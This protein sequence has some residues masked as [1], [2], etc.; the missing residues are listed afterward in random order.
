[1]APGGS[2]GGEHRSQAIMEIV[3]RNLPCCH[4]PPTNPYPTHT[5]T[6]GDNRL[7]PQPAAL[8]AVI[9]QP[10]HPQ[11]ADIRDGAAARRQRRQRGCGEAAAAGAE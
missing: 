1:V 9:P 7:P 2:A 4:Q 10:H 6:P 8:P 5:H 3:T 11:A